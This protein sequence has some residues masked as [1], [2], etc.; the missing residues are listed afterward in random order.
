MVV[1]EALLLLLLQARARTDRPSTH[2]ERVAAV[3]RLTWVETWQG[4]QPAPSRHCI[5]VVTS[6]E[7]TTHPTVS[8]SLWGA[9]VRARLELTQ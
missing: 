4:L 6:A 3:L 2:V 7:R 8:Y 5:T 1:A 9:V